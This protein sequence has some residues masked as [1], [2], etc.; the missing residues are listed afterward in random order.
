[1]APE[2]CDG[3]CARLE[4]LCIYSAI[5]QEADFTV[6]AVINAQIVQGEAITTICDDLILIEETGSSSLTIAEGSILESVLS[7]DVEARSLNR[8]KAIVTAIKVFGK[9]VAASAKTKFTAAGMAVNEGWGEFKGWV[10]DW[11]V[12]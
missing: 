6:N 11:S 10:K 2:L 9:N 4:V 7:S 8:G 5:I 12:W 1:M 3:I